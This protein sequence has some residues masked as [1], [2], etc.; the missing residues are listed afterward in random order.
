MADLIAVKTRLK[1]NTE[2]TSNRR[3]VKYMNWLFKSSIYFNI[4]FVLGLLFWV[5]LGFDF[6]ND[7]LQIIAK[8]SNQVFR[9]IASTPQDVYTTKI[10]EDRNILNS[11]SDKELESLLV[12]G[13]NSQRTVN[14]QLQYQETFLNSFEGSYVDLAIDEDGNKLV[15]SSSNSIDYEDTKTCKANRLFFEKIIEAKKKDVSDFLAERE[16]PPETDEK[17]MPRRC[18]TNVMN[19]FNLSSY[20]FARCAGPTGT[21]VRGEAKPCISKSLVNYTYNAL[22][23]V[24]DCMNINPKSLLPKLS[25]ES[26]LIINT[27]GSG[28]DAGVGQLT[29]DAIE[30]VNKYYDGYLKEIQAAA[31]TGKASCQRILKN[32]KLLTKV[33][34]LSGS[35]CG[36]IAAVENPLRNILYMGVYNRLNSDYFSGIKYKAGQDYLGDKIVKN[37]PSDDLAGA[38]EKNN[39]KKLMK[40]AGLEVDK[41][42]F[43]RVVEMVNLVGYNAGPNTAFKMFLDY[44]NR[45]IAH[46]KIPQVK[47]RFLTDADFNFHDPKKQKD[48]IDGVERT[49]VEIARL[50]VSAPMIKKDEKPNK[51]RLDRVRALPEKM[52]TAHLLTFPEFLIYRQNNFDISILNPANLAK[53]NEIKNPEDR[54]KE[55]EKYPSYKTLAAPG[56]LNFLAAKDNAIRATFESAGQ[57]P[58]LCSDKNFLKI[59]P[60]N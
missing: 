5:I 52:R 26:G 27:F 51:T 48:E 40:E 10:L 57:S 56:Y 8:E 37:D 6:E 36:L 18:V 54:E 49:V 3:C 60:V 35:R 15:S 38:F 43:N 59:K 53:V 34:E 31:A 24:A 21:P 7:E 9:N 11:I 22:I 55:R 39:V 29:G 16:D 23:D 44:L 50:N 42:N 1:S 32:P 25:N 46:N 20:F 19:K 17:A 41:I 33:Q 30:E 2:I 28:M 47:K 14:K 12:G 13:Q 4:C 58:W 45:R